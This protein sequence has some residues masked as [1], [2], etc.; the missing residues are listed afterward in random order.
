MT[1]HR[2]AIAALAATALSA[3]MALPAIAQ[4]ESDV[5]QAVE[6]SEDELQSYA[7][8]A[9][10]IEVLVQEWQPRVQDA[11]TPEDAAELGQ[12]A[13]AEMVQAVESEG[14]TVEQYNQITQLAQADPDLQARIMTYIQ[15]Q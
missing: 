5:P 14:L 10:E 13:Q 6:L 15:A 2:T 4:I 9:A 11:E 1:F 12:Q 8:A 3:T 7:A